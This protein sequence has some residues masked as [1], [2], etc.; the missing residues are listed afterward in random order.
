MLWRVESLLVE[1]HH[2]PQ[3]V[4][5]RERE[6]DWS[7][8]FQQANKSTVPQI[9]KRQRCSLAAAGI[10]RPTLPPNQNIPLLRHY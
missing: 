6:K 8:N 3:G 7:C 4:R 1:W 10:L 2:H 5:L 9:T